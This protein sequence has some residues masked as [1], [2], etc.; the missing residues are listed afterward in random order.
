MLITHNMDEA[1]GCDRVVV[2]DSG[3]ILTQGR[4]CEVFCQVDRLRRHHLD[5]PQATELCSRLLGYGIDFDRLPLDTE[6]CVQMLA[7]VLI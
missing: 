5:V 4:P 2:M 7:E 3:R 6:E 1:I